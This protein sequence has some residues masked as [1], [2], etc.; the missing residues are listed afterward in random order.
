MQRT[1]VPQMVVT[2]NSMSHLT[3]SLLSQEISRNYTN[4]KEPFK[5]GF[6]KILR[7]VQ[8]E[9][10]NFIWYKCLNVVMYSYEKH[11]KY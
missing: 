9:R 10:R 4:T 8:A 11:Y 7:S 5:A 2:K 3:V 6:D 1:Y